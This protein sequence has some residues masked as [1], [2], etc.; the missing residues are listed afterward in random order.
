MNQAFMD[1]AISAASEGVLRREGGPFGAVVVREGRILAR[2]WNR[3]VHDRDP[4]AHAEVNAIREACRLLGRFHLEDCDLYASCEPCPM[5]LGAIYWARLG[6][7]Y[8]A[9]TREHAAGIGFSDALIYSELA[10]DPESRA[11]RF[12]KVDA[13]AAAAVMTAWQADPEKRPY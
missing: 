11:V 3:V 4:T 2:A 1:A 12:V 9:A 7:V 5:C 10:R 6:A 8:Y 13:A